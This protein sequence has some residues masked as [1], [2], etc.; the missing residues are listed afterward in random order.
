MSVSDPIAPD[1]LE[2]LLRG[3]TGGGR[4]RAPHRSAARRAHGRRDR[5]ARRAARARALAHDCAARD[6]AAPRRPT[7]LPPA[8]AA[9][10]SR[11]R[12]RSRRGG[13]RARGSRRD[14]DADV[15]RH[16]SRSRRPDGRRQPSQ[17]ASSRRTTGCCRRMTA[18]PTLRARGAP[19]TNGTPSTAPLPDGQRAQDY[20]AS[21]R[22]AV[23]SVAE[24]S[25]STQSVLD[26]VRS[27]GGAV[28][29]RRLRHADRRQRQRADR[30]ARPRR[31]RTGGAAALLGARHDH[32]AT[33]ADPRSPGGSRPGDAIACAPCATASTLLKAKL[34]S[35]SLTRRRAR[36]AREPPRRLAERRSRASCAASTRRSSAPPSRASR[37]ISSPAAARP[38]RRRLQPGA[39]ERTADDALG[40]ISVAGRGALFAAI[41][42]GPFVLLAGGRLVARAPAQAPG[43][44]AVAREFV[45]RSR[46]VVA[47]GA[48]GACRQRRRASTR[49]PAT[50]R[51]A[52]RPAAPCTTARRP[53]ASRPCRA[54]SRRLQR[55]AAGQRQREC[56]ARPDAEVERQAERRPGR[57]R[58]PAASARLPMCASCSRRGRPV[59]PVRGTRARRGVSRCAGP[60]CRRPRSP[61]P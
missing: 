19:G 56:P 32:G 49:A 61:S 34:L 5:A 13:G 21:L 53:R 4:P 20:A 22:L 48:E 27:L 45:T 23:G 41:V 1:R 37:S 30:P 9:R 50:R 59:S 54:T 31:A 29:T 24:L 17:R 51:P 36:D 16:R 57:A 11:S 6:R 3:E 42:V 12:A 46:D 15:R 60:R 14:P 28:V 33:G 35:P 44:A 26:T 43:C 58:R 7:G 18:Q 25:R 40:V 10:A 8:P 55:H 39:F 38:S 52:R 2:A 47:P